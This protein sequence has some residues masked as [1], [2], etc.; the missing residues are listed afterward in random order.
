MILRRDIVREICIASVTHQFRLFLYHS[1]ILGEKCGKSGR[2][3]GWGAGWWKVLTWAGLL[4]VLSGECRL[5]AKDL[6]VLG[7]EMSRLGV[8]YVVVGAVSDL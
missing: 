4:S 7:A 1:K 2:V 3:S 8:I 6:W 5:F